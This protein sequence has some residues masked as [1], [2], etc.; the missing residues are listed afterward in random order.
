[1]CRRVLLIA[2]TAPC[3]PVRDLFIVPGS[4]QTS[5]LVWWQERGEVAAP[6]PVYP[7]LRAGETRP[8]FIMDRS[9][10]T[11]GPATESS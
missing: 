2:G 4:G 1:M 8:G 5:L 9:E 11:S 10:V 6:I 7:S 3:L